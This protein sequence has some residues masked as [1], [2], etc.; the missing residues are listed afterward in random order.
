MR[1]KFSQ[2]PNNIHTEIVTAVGWGPMNELFS[3]SDDKNIWKWDKST[4]PVAKAGSVDTYITDM[5]WFPSKRQAGGA[6]SEIFVVA[7][8]DGSYRLMNKTGREEKKVDKAHAGAVTALRWSYDG[9]SLL[10]AGEDG[11]LKVWSRNGMLRSTLLQTGRCIYSIA[12]SPNDDQ[13]LLTSGKELV[14]K[15]IQPSSK[16]IQWQA[17]DAPVLKV[18]W[19]PVNNL[20]VSGGEDCKYKVWDCYG[21]MLY[22]SK[23]AD[24][25]ITSVSWAP[26]G[27]TFAVGSFNSLRLCDKTGWSYCRERTNSGSIFNISWTSDST[28]LA[29]AGGN[30]A[31]CFGHIVER[32]MNWK[33]IEVL[34]DEATHIKVSDV[35][36]NEII[37]EMNYRDRV[38]KMALGFAH[39][40]VATATQCHVY[41]AQHWNAPTVFDLKDTVNFIIQSEKNFLIVDNF[42]G[43]QVYNYDGRLLCTPK[44]K[45][46][47][48]E[49]LNSNIVSLSSDY[50]A[51]VDRTDPRSIHV[52][53]LPSGK[54]LNVEL[55]HGLDIAEISLNHHGA[56]NE[57]K[58]ALIDR[59]QDLHITPVHKKAFVKMA[60][61]VSSAIWSDSTGMLAAIVDGKFVVWYYPNVVYID[62]NLVEATKNIKDG[63]DFGKTCQLVTFYGN[64]CT[65]RR[66][67]GS[68]ISASVSPYPILLYQYVERNE[69]E[70]AIRLCRFVKDQQ[71]WSTLSAMA[72][73][74]KE[75]NTAEVAFAAIEEVDRLQYI[76]HIREIP[77][78]EGQSAELHLF[79]RQP[80]DA[81]AILLQGGLIYRAIKLNIHLFRWERALDLALKHKTHI[82]TVIGYRAK[83][84]KEWNKTEN[85]PKFVKFSEGVE[86]DWEKIKAK[87]TQ[88][89]EKERA[90]YSGQ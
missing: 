6:S 58:I 4:E 28:Q 12:W 39:L 61:M 57:R 76:T 36:T 8:T 69:W 21:R 5:H 78:P 13:I 27:D 84:L 40:I 20:I 46:L 52:I 75:L 88:E 80:D 79:R 51:I 37:E 66:A 26:D 72:M 55:T 22:Q 82:D 35:N 68:L 44:F 50:V 11:V 31:V 9:T 74:N 65:G 16:Q 87:I 77:S 15:P 63:S 43:I 42:T 25:V 54:P 53:E 17:H 24:T 18:D 49:F 29:G 56:S 1:L 89:K 73:N 41:S 71:L 48:S 14:I 2:H 38:I 23:V 59:N 60:S 81:E 10:T 34:L 90:R 47:R 32:R 62:R 3:C 85:N 7:C 86:V 83:Y 64:L 45:G 67:D 33:N 19:N 30:G 70:S